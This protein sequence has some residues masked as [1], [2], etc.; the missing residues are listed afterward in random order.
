MFDRTTPKGK[1]VEAALQLA[2]ARPW[3]DVTLLDLADAAGMPLAEVRKVAGSKSQI[4]AALMRGFDDEVLGRQQRRTAGQPARDSLFEVVMSR[5]DVMQPHKA[6]LKSI[7]DAGAVD[8][9]LIMPFLNS[10]RWMLAAA[11]IDADGPTG[12]ARTAGFGALYA[13]VFRTWLADDDP[14]MAKTMAA[15]D[16]GLRRGERT[17]GSIGDTVGG[18]ARVVRDLPGVLRDVLSRG[19]ASPTKT[20]PPTT[21]S[22]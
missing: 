17:L 4:L 19:R 7:A 14:G 16:Q 21:G 10:Q 5:F 3:H 1:L 18:I 22:P 2:S 8:T 15:L 9:T 12:L 13:S 6:A 20:E 11:G